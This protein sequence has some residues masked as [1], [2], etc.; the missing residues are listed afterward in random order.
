MRRTHALASATFSA[1]LRRYRRLAEMTGRQLSKRAGLHPG[2]VAKYETGEYAPTL[3]AFD[4]LCR[5]LKR[6]PNQLMGYDDET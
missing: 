6:T 5:A 2:A 4:A 3:D 1:K